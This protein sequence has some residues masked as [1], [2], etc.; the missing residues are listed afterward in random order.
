MI[1]DD[2]RSGRVTWDDIAEDIDAE[3]D[4]LK[5]EL[6]AQGYEVDGDE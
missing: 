1:N 4:G 2:L 3:L 6:R 5:A